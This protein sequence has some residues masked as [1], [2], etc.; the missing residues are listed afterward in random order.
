MGSYDKFYNKGNDC[1]CCINQYR[2]GRDGD[3]EA[4]RRADE[5]QDRLFEECSPPEIRTEEGFYGLIGQ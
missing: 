5:G 2:C 4:C 3:A 1:D